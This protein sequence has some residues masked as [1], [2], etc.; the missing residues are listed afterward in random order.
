M[1]NCKPALIKER[2][3]LRRSERVCVF[4]GV[5][6]I[7]WDAPTLPDIMTRSMFWSGSYQDDVLACF[8]LAIRPAGVVFDIGAAAIV[9]LENRH[10]LRDLGYRMFL[11]KPAFWRQSARRFQEMTLE[12]SL[13]NSLINVVC[14]PPARTDLV[15]KV[16][17]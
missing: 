6:G 9:T 10:L 2:R 14:L 13:D 15:A 16:L 4:R 8:H 17:P 1:I 12:A 5:H 7:L 11:P 3:P